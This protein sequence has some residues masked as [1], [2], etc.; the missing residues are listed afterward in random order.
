MTAT[1]F[2]DSPLLG[3][4]QQIE[5]GVFN[6]LVQAGDPRKK[7]MRYR[8]FCRHADGTECTMIGHK[9]IADDQ[10]QPEIWDDT[11]T[12]Y[13]TLYR[14][15]ADRGPGNDRAAQIATGILKI[16]F[17]DFLRELTTF[18]LQ[19]PRSDRRPGA[20]RHALA[21]EAGG[22][23]RRVPGAELMLVSS[24]VSNDMKPTKT[25]THMEK[26]TQREGHAPGAGGL[27]PPAASGRV[28]LRPT[29]RMTDGSRVTARQSSPRGP[30]VHRAPGAA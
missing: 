27:S 19:G 21:R 1:G 26:T 13:T 28:D 17:F 14:G 10:S 2:L 11:T 24:D 18:R 25:M 6:L 7:E 8:L 3:G 20:L 9:K 5:P 23:L 30:E 29:A 22:R 16:Q 15:R 12:L 4:R